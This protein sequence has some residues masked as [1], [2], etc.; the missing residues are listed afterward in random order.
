MKSSRKLIPAALLSFAGI[1]FAF[2]TIAA[3]YTY[4]QLGRLTSVVEADGSTASYTYDAN[5]N[6]LTIAR[7][8]P[9][10]AVSITSFAPATGTAGTSLVIRGVGFSPVLAQNSVSFNG[11][12]GTV[13]AANASEIIAVAPPGVTT[14]TISVTSPAGSAVS[15]S[16]FVVTPVR[17]TAFTPTRGSAGATVTITGAGFD[18]LPGNNYVKFNTATAAVLSATSTELQ[19]TVPAN[20]TSGR[21][22]VTAGSSSGESS[23]D[24]FVPLA[25]YAAADIQMTGRIVPGGVGLIYTVAGANKLATMLFDGT[26]GQRI[27]LVLN[28]RTLGGTFF[29]YAPDGTLVTSGFLHLSTL[30]DLPALPTTGTYT[31]YFAPGTQ[32]GSATVRLETDAVGSV[33]TDG[34]PLPLS[35]AVGQNAD[36]TFAA[37][38]GQSFNLYFSPFH[39]IPAGG[40]MA[41]AIH[42]LDGTQLASCGTINANFGPC[43]F[44]TA[45][46]GTY[47]VRINP[48]GAAAM[49][50]QMRLNADLTGELQANV[51]LSFALPQA[52][53]ALFTF[54][55]AAGDAVALNLENVVVPTPTHKAVQLNVYGPNGAGVGSTLSTT[56]Q[57][58][59]NNYYDLAAG[60]HTVWVRTYDPMATASMQL[61]MAKFGAIVLPTD[62][63]P[64]SYATTVPGQEGIFRFTGT[65]GQ[66][67]GLGATNLSINPTSVSN[68]AFTIYRPNGSQYRFMRDYLNSSPG[69]GSSLDKLPQSGVYTVVA[70][71]AGHATMGFTLSLTHNATGNLEV[72]SPLPVNLDVPGRIGTLSFSAVANETFA[73]YV[74]SI[75]T[76]PAGK[77]VGVTVKN[78]GGAT[79]GNA[80][81]VGS[82]TTVN[83]PYLAAGDY[84]VW[85]TTANAATGTMDVTLAP[86]LTGTLPLNSSVSFS[87][88]VPGQSGYFKFSGTSGQRLD[89]AMTG[90]SLNPSSPSNITSN[91]Y[92]P[93]WNWYRMFHGYLSSNPGD[94][95][96]F[97][98]LPSTGNYDVIAAPNGLS[99]ANYTLTL[100]QAVAAALTPGTPYSLSLALPGQSAAL[101]F[102]QAATQSRTLNV[103]SI[104]TVPANKQVSVKVINAAGSTVKSA[105]GT[106]AAISLSMPNLGAGTYTVL[107]TIAN[108]STANMQLDLQ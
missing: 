43:R 27:T 42:R 58:V 88:S 2:H 70:A 52:R 28:N 99:I 16:A 29:L 1:L 71:P 90:L 79:V 49:T 15:A 85:L 59:T 5:G 57:G 108:A 97:G 4:D 73:L 7:T 39:S 98:A 104:A 75:A 34:T 106:G 45:T 3:Q 92:R 69:E 22:S 38:G 31:L 53:H 93:T 96:N 95:L 56:G 60:V 100:S 6:I 51:P 26:Q 36:F 67:L 74:S 23:S 101:T 55:A 68:V 17:V 44:T 12:L 65:A 37:A 21:I 81:T 32:T 35:L 11:Q 102:T 8:S 103:S 94:A 48:Q 14:G 30:L 82:A 83:L 40:V 91:V 105:S 25:G 13:T 107:I 33:P 78:S 9:A 72:G 66:N 86:G 54:T 80:S 50:L 62:G 77:Q 19:V 76:N 18:S 41:V 46:A 47:R 20:A 10:P 24:F 64:V 89:L 87:T 84:T 61:T 63:T